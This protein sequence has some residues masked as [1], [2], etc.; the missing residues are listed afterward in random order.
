MTGTPRRRR[1]EWTTSV[2][3]LACV[4]QDALDSAAKLKGDD[5][6]G[7]YGGYG[8]LE[9][10]LQMLLEHR[11]LWRFCAKHQRARQA[12]QTKDANEFRAKVDAKQAE[13]ERNN[14]R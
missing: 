2:R 14:P 10:T 7:V 4:A 9:A 5:T 3:C 11:Y 12:A 1:N 6:A 8:Y 13:W